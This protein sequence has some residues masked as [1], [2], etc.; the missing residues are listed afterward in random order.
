M[1][2][3]TLIKNLTLM[4]RITCC[5]NLIKFIHLRKRWK[6]SER[7]KEKTK[8]NGKCNLSAPCVYL[9]KTMRA[10]NIHTQIHLVICIYL[11]WVIRHFVGKVF[12]R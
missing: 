11:K 5:T 10:L 3:N 4:S 1:Q 6:R 7:Q 2:G 9:L 12:L 8:E